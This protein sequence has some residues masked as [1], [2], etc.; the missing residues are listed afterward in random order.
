MASKTKRPSGDNNSDGLVDASKKIRLATDQGSLTLRNLSGNS[1]PTSTSR[2]S[3]IHAEVDGSGFQVLLKGHGRL[4]RQFKVLEVDASGVINSN[5]GWQ[6]VR[7]AL[8][9]GWESVFGDVI[10]ADGVIG[11]STNADVNGN[12]LLD[13]GQARGYQ[14]LAGSDSDEA[15]TLRSSN[16]KP[17]SKHSSKRWDAV[18]AVSVEDGFQ[19]LLQKGSR[20]K[21]AFKLLN[22][23]ADGITT[24][25][26]AWLPQAEALFAG[27]DVRFKSSILES[28]SSG[29]TVDAASVGDQDHIYVSPD[30]S[31]S[32]PGSFELPL[33]TIT[34]ASTLAQPGDQ[35]KLRGGT[36][37]ERVYINDLHGTEDEPITISNY[38]DEKVVI[39]GAK[40]IESEW[41][42]YEAI[43]GKQQLILML[44]SYSL[45]TR[46]SSG[47]A[48]Q[49]SVNIGM[50][51]M[52][53]MEIIRLQAATGI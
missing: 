12:G 35:I 9:Q 45:M 28:S 18:Q 6:P 4:R 17:L 7:K 39:E 11:R 43:S 19:V 49:T 27:W 52:S 31:D 15:V 40:G 44:L 37:K 32:N 41:V 34:Y 42:S 21:P 38:D 30:G 46:C 10:K 36:Y 3:V 20:R 2:R 33:A 8:S 48:G 25:K 22:V 1:R 50:N 51:T 24:E 53:P 14:I 23:G 29:G 26:S 5:S 47:R 16:G 13:R